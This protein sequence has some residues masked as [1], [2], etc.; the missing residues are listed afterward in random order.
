LENI[1]IIATKKKGPE[2]TQCSF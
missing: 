2:A 1:Q